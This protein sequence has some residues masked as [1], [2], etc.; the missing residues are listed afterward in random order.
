MHTIPGRGRRARAAVPSLAA[1]I[2]FGASALGASFGAPAS[3]RADSITLTWTA[4]GDDGSAGRATAYE[5]RFSEQPV[6]GVDTTSWWNSAS[7]AGVLPPPATSGTRES[8]VMSG[9]ATGST[10]HFVLR[11]A[12]E[13]GNWSGFSN[14]RA[15]QAGTTGGTL[16]T[17]ESFTASAVSG[18]VDLTWTEPASG[19]GSGYH[20]YRRT[21]AGPDTLLTSLP[22][23]VVAWCD[24]TAAGGSSYEYRLATY[25]GSGEGVP[26]VASIAV[27]SDRLANA[28]TG[29]HGYPNPARGRV[30]LRFAG[31]TKEGAPGR[32]RLVIYDLTGHMVCQLVDRVLPAGEQAIEWPC[33]SDAGNAV[34]PGLYNAILDA[35]Q[36]RTVTRIAVVP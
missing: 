19:S 20:L 18:G 31:G 3:A 21:S 13:A 8:Y 36:G 4:T 33:R 22:V 2:L 26:A 6:S 16:A 7:T 28:T 10:Y 5:L 9:L 12:D 30:T 29:I 24:S 15:R 25:Q 34:A 14:V 17:P 35:P 27:P 23:G 11:V 1:A 32:V